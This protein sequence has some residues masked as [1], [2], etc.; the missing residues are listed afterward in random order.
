MR[1]EPIHPSARCSSSS[2]QQC[3][4]RWRHIPRPPIQLEAE[5]RRGVLC[6]FSACEGVHRYCQI[7]FPDT[8]SRT[9]AAYSQCY[10]TADLVRVF[11]RLNSARG[12]AE[13]YAGRHEDGGMDFRQ[14]SSRCCDISR[15]SRA[16]VDAAA[17]AH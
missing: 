1:I 7:A 9:P 8:V 4:D 5:A 6:L 17:S 16:A 15:C 10:R 2:W 3:L 11:D 14:S 12:G 13:K